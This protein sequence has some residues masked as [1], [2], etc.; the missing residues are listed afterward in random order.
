MSISAFL[1]VYNE[2]NRIEDTLTSLMWCDEIILID[3]KSNDRTVDIALTFGNKVKVYSINNSS[4]YDPIEWKIFLDNSSS[5]W[6]IIFTASDV[7]HPKLV[8]DILSL[9]RKDKFD[10]DIIFLPFKRL[11]L[12]LESNKSPWHSKLSPKVV[13]KSSIVL[14]L[15]G[16]HDAVEF[17]GNKI[18][19]PYNNVYCMYHLTHE[20]ADIMMDRHVRYWRGEATN[21]KTDLKKAFKSVLFG[22]INLLFIRRTWTL[23]YDGLML[24]FSYLSHLMMSYVY[25]WEKSRGN[26]PQIYLKI[27]Y[28]I[29]DEWKKQELNLDE[30]Y[31]K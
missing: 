16:V 6:V 24:M 2:E 14:N 27:K 15:D 9:I 30:Y 31:R 17:I 3:K 7:I 23:G 8:D 28:E 10:F 25:K 22:F 20:T 4:N 1:P 26:A 18:Q 21:D 13:R 29:K 11:V 19:L 12:G 5:E